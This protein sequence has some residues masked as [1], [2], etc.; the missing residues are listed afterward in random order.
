MN[1]QDYAVDPGYLFD[2]GDLYERER[3]LET[4]W[5]LAEAA[6]AGTPKEALAILERECGVKE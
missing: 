6:R 2:A 1:G 4:T 5:A 3:W